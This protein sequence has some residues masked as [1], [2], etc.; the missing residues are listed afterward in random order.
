[1]GLARTL[2]GL[3]GSDRQD[4]PNIRHMLEVNILTEDKILPK[5]LVR[6]PGENGLAQLIQ[7]RFSISTLGSTDCWKT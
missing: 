6:P 7:P 2:S 3:T 1:M 5:W 4:Y